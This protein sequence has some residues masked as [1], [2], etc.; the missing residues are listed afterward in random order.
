MLVISGLIRCCVSGLHLRYSG[1]IIYKEYLR[2]HFGTG[3][4]HLQVSE[5]ADYDKSHTE[6]DDRIYYWGDAVQLYYLADRRCANENIWPYYAGAYHPR[7]DL[8]G[9]RTT[10][11]IVD[12]KIS[13]E[14]PVWMAD[15]LAKSYILETTILGEGIYRYIG[16]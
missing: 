15:L 10:Y 6:P 8:F 13:D 1:D 11:M 4:I 5:I 14:M 9:L 12:G 3:V 7:E 16:N 2:G